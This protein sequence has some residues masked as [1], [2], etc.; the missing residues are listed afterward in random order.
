MDFV[1]MGDIM[2]KPRQTQSDRWKK[3]SCVVRYRNI[4]TAMAL[5]ANKEGYNPTPKLKAIIGIQM[6]K[7]WT[8][9]K[10]AALL[11]TPHR[12]KPDVDNLIKTIMD[13]LCKQDEYIYHIDVKKFWAEESFVILENLGDGNE[14]KFNLRHHLQGNQVESE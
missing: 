8:K 5:Q 14:E 1:Y 10:K 12:Q 2:G 7:S 11:H 6:P 9:K 4:A 13:A 3:R